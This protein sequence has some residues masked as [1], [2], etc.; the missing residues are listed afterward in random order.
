MSDFDPYYKWLG[1]PPDEQ[2]PSY[3]RLLG[4]PNFEADPDV[5]D[6]AVNQRMAHIRTFQLTFRTSWIGNSVFSLCSRQ[7]SLSTVNN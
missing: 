7:T 1:I 6:N 2:P 3:Y 5:I 4:L